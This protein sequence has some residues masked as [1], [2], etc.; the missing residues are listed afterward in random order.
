MRI[1]FRRTH[2]VEHVGATDLQEVG[3]Q[4]AMAAPPNGF[5]THDRGPSFCRETAKSLNAAREFL[6]LHVVGV[7]AKRLV[8]PRGIPRIGTRF[9]SAAELAEMFVADS[10]AA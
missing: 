1:G 2:N 10:D 3:D 5:S 4:S 8:P 7:T 6:R 9:S